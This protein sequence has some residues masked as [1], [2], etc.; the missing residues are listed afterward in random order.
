MNDEECCGVEACSLSWIVMGPTHACQLQDSE[1]PMEVDSLEN[2]MGPRHVC[3]EVHVVPGQAL[4]PET[5][6]AQKLAHHQGNGIGPNNS[7]PL[8]NDREEPMDV[9]SPPNAKRLRHAK[10]LE[11]G[12]DTR[13]ANWSQ[14]DEKHRH[15]YH[16][17]NDKNYRH[18]HH[19]LPSDLRHRF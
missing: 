6:M 13:H 10:H 4:C 8:V 12:V 16:S 15:G 14:N 5:D 19:S 2:D 9:S 7:W 1:K 17:G 18:G 11:N 3:Y